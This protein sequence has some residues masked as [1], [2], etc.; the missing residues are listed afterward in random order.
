[1]EVEGTGFQ[2]VFSTSEWRWYS[3]MISKI[4]SNLVSIIFFFFFLKS[5]SDIW[6]NQP[7]SDPMLQNEANFLSIPLCFLVI[8]EALLAHPRWK[9]EE[10]EWEKV[11]PH[12]KCNIAINVVT[13]VHVLH[14]AVEFLPSCWPFFFLWKTA[15]YE[16]KAERYF[17]EQVVLTAT[18]RIYLAGFQLEGMSR[19]KCS[20]CLL[21]GTETHC[22]CIPWASPS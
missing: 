9:G 20:S 21:H 11:G 2:K 12:G 10:C 6:L 16:S 22:L 8:L 14:H 19:N 17:L 18:M 13:L 4:E 7:C 15:P 3:Y 5:T 1:M